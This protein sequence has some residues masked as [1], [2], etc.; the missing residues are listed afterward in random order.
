MANQRV[1]G[2]RESKS[3]FTTATNGRGIGDWIIRLR[4]S[5]L[6]KKALGDEQS[7]PVRTAT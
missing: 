7:P 1:A 4:C 5:E 3:S 2:I 6:S